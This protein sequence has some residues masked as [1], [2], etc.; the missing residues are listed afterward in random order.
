MVGKATT[1]ISMTGTTLVCNQ[2]LVD[3]RGRHR[4]RLRLMSLTALASLVLFGC[5]ESGSLA[6]PLSPTDVQV[7]RL[8]DGVE[9]SLPAHWV[10]SLPPHPY[11]LFNIAERDSGPRPDIASIGATSPH[12]DT[13]SM[14]LFADP[15]QMTSS[16]TALAEWLTS[17]PSFQQGSTGSA[18]AGGFSVDSGRPRFRPRRRCRGSRMMSWQSHYVRSPAQ[19]AN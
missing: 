6:E 4:M 13:L 3:L 11:S 7:V 12:P 10:I 9:F 17:F 19:S 14:L 15:P 1:P 16:T 2:K 8:V 18:S 5:G